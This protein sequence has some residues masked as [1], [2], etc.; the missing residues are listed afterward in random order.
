MSGDLVGDPRFFVLLSLVVM[1]VK[2]QL[3]SRF[4]ISSVHPQETYQPFSELFFYSQEPFA[5]THRFSR[6]L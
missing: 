3:T 1:K 5:F 2:L 6:T 4:T